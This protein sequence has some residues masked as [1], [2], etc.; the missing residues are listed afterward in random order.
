MF[1]SLSTQWNI[2]QTKGREAVHHNNA[3]LKDIKP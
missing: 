1:K 3:K 2:I